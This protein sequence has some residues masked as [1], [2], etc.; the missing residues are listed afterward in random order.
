MPRILVQLYPRGEPSQ[1]RTYAR[2][3]S[4]PE[5]QVPI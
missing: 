2:W 3:V 4:W 1:V 5:L